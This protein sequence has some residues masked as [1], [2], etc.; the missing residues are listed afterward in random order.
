MFSLPPRLRLFPVLLALGS[1][2]LAA[3]APDPIPPTGG[4]GITAL[5]VPLIQP[6]SPPA[7][8]ATA[9]AAPAQAK[10]QADYG[11]LPYTFEANGGQ[12]DAAV[13]FLARGPGYSLFLTP[14]EAVL[15]L[16][17]K[18]P[19]K[20]PRP[21]PG[22]RPE[23]VPGPTPAA[24][25]E[26]T[27]AATPPAVLRLSLIGA[28]P[29]PVIRGEAA[30][31]GKVNYL[32]GKDPA[33][34]RTGLSTYAKVRYEG[35]YPGVDLVYYGSQG[36]LE[37]DLV[38]APGADPT[39]IRL[40]FAGADRMGLDDT[41]NLVLTL[42]DQQVIQ[43]TPRVYQETNGERTQVPT[44]Y[45]LADNRQVSLAVGDYD[46]ERALVIDPVL[47]YSTYLG[48]SDQD[49]GS[50]IAV[51]GAGNAYLTGTTFS[52]DFPT[53]NGQQPDGHRFVAKLSADGATL[54]YSTF[55]SFGNE[56]P[57][58]AVD[59]AG[60]AFVAG[61]T[62][63]DVVPTRNAFQSDPG[64]GGDAFVAKLSADGAT[65]V[66]AS[67]L[68]GSGEDTGYGIAVDGAG[69]AYVTGSTRSTD[70]PTRNALQ[71][72]IG[73]DFNDPSVDAFVAKVSPDGATLV[74][75]SYLGGFYDDFSLGVAVDG[76]G[77]A[78]LTGWTV[79]RDFPTRN[80]LQPDFGGYTDVFV[81]KISADGATLVYASYL[82]GRGEE[83][84]T[85]IAV[86]SVGNA[87][88]TGYALNHDDPWSDTGFPTH[89]ALFNF[90]GFVD[91]F[92]AKISADGTA[93][94]YSTYLGGERADEGTG[95][96]VDSAGNAYV[97]GETL[98]VD[99]PTHRA[100]QPNSGHIF[101]VKLSADGTTFV[102]G[103]KL[104]GSPDVVQPSAIAVDGAGNAYLTGMTA[105]PNFP[106][107]NALQPDFAG[108]SDAFVAKIADVPTAPAA[109][110]PWLTALGDLTGDGHQ[111]LAVLFEEATAGTVT[112]QIKQ[113]V[114]GTL[115]QIF[116][117]EQGYAPLD[118]TVVPDQNSNGAPELA[119]LG[120]RATD[121]RVQ[122]EVR[123]T[124]TGERLTAVAFNP[125]FA[126]QRLAVLP[127]R[128]GN[129][130]AE[131]AVLGINAGNGAI[132][133]AIKDAATGAGLGQIFFAKTFRPVDFAAVADTNGNG[134]A[135]LAVLGV[136]SDGQP[137][138][139]LRDSGNAVLVK[140]LWSPKWTT[141]LGLVE[142]PD[143]NGN[144]TPEVA[145]LG[146]G[147]KA[148]VVKTADAGTAAQLGFVYYNR[149]FMPHQVAALPDLNAN[150]VAELAVLGRD[151]AG[152][153]NT[154]LR[155]AVTGALVRNLQFEQ[156]APLDLAVLPDLNGNG[157]PEVAVLGVPA[158]GVA[159]VLIMDSASQA[160]ISRLDF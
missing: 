147:T 33:A 45:V 30:L 93:L 48:G 137:R 136:N 129:G 155:D 71:P 32:T 92:V 122:V 18:E 76:A 90:G 29:D 10:I 67:Y 99:F 112:A 132:A 118:L 116:D 127:D 14:G 126:P 19:N 156:L 55:F 133:A 125:V 124:R 52:D 157:S 106:T 8:A 77:N 60:N 58:I 22:A 108:W 131:L 78:Y 79:S 12:A 43:Q 111:Y 11:K 47:V 104:G 139:E 36:Q 94:L 54:V 6:A 101:L 40:A 57:V 23:P 148:V 35:V 66:Y 81:A 26:P 160:Q 41:G 49:W 51:D 59:N 138:V 159:Q 154:E 39:V 134:V 96:A 4:A 13:K 115:I 146:Q 149:N 37:Y 27:A 87:Y 62:Y 20:A 107:R 130:S 135:E 72:D 61:Y 89:Q 151:A 75:S 109:A 95:I 120:L 119:L 25:L 128:N 102:Y 82:G 34:W 98:S 140:V 44:R 121:R 53:G 143:A 123:D 113:A 9:P 28:N 83:V 2:L 5:A 50:H 38:L 85:G 97:T 88:L 65:L 31:P 7:S 70:F 73:G 86:D 142:V 17:S 74:Y 80:A 158:G 15:S 150:G 1:G 68:G 69:N 105:A 141:P 64:G 144:G 24:V 100:M 3:A 103:I 110:L 16:H 145:V 117:F 114:S 91:A 63:E 56:S 153:L 42:G 84:G 46:A 21:R 152:Q